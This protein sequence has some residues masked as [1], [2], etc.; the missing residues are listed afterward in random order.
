M[1][2]AAYGCATANKETIM[3]KA[4]IN[5]TIHVVLDRSG[6]MET[7]RDTTLKAVNDYISQVAKDAPGST[8]SI[9]TF[10]DR[11][12]LTPVKDQPI[13]SA[14]LHPGDFEPRGMT[15][16]YDAIGKVVG[17]LDNATAQDKALV[18][19]TDGYENAS[20]KFTAKQIKTM[21]D[22]R[23][24]NENWLVIYLGANQDAIVEGQK[25]GAKA[26]TSMSYDTQNMGQTMTS[27][28]RSTVAYASTAKL[29]EKLKAASFTKKER[30][31]AKK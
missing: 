22:D 5:L 11:E 6:S 30:E 26:S 17:D 12:I 24:E 18:I 1:M 4:K 14:V 2:A 15:P 9:T 29:S 20:R 23:Q 13:T 31:E 10:D 3:T 27:S 21:L 16:L 25:F 19:V 8:I 28:A 7:C